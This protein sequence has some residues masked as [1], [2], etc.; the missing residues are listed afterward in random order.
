MSVFHV[1]K[2]KKKNEIMI[3]SSHFWVCF[4]DYFFIFDMQ[5]LLNE[6]LMWTESW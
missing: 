4:T 6:S 3:L 5:S 1:K 2:K